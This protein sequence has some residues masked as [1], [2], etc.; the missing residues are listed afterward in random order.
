MQRIKKHYLNTNQLLPFL[1]A[2]LI[3]IF[4]FVSH[5][6]LKFNYNHQYFS[7]KYR[8]SQWVIPNSKTPISDEDL[9][10]YAGNEYVKGTSPIL[11]NPEILPLPKYIIG[12]VTQLTKNPYFTGG[13]FYLIALIFALK[14]INLKSQ[15]TAIKTLVLL[16]IL[17]EITRVDKILTALIEPF[18]LAFFLIGLYFYLKKHYLS[19]AISFALFINS[20]NFIVYFAL[21][22][23]TLAIDIALTFIQKKGVKQKIQLIFLTNLFSLLFLYLNYLKVILDTKNLVEPSKIQKYIFSFYKNSAKTSP[24]MALKMIFLNR[25]DVWWKDTPKNVPGWNIIWPLSILFFFAKIMKEKKLKFIH[26]WIII[27]L[28]F[29]NFIPVWPRYFLLIFVPV[30]LALV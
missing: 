22:N 4:L 12:T 8:H 26:L 23:L 15:N 24:L 16:L 27:Y 11:I 5:P 14:I 19:A 20:K 2:L 9:Y 6:R 18:L 1:L 13:I 7:Q 29:L 21:F 10:I 3:F 25:W 28:T 30:Y 17:W